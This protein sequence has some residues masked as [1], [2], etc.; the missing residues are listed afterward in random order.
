MESLEADLL[1]ICR[2]K[3]YEHNYQVVTELD[4]IFKKKGERYV[5]ENME[6][7]L[8]KLQ[9]FSKSAKELNTYA[10]VLLRAKATETSKAMTVFKMNTKLFPKDKNCY[11][12]L[13][14]A[15]FVTKNYEKATENY[16][17]VLELDP[18]DKNAKAMLAKMKG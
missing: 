6:K 13:A 17:K 16:N 4:H 1:K 14:E 7:V 9:P 5:T 2:G 10:Y 8:S 18:T 12:S 15:Y 3:S 11:D